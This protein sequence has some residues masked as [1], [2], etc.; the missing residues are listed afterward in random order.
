LFTVPKRFQPFGNLLIVPEQSLNLG[1]V[2]GIQLTIEV[3]IEQFI[4]IINFILAH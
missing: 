4:D 3:T 1:P 2:P